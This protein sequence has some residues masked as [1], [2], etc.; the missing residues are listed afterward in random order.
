M[1]ALESLQRFINLSMLLLPQRA[2]RT[3]ILFLVLRRV[4]ELDTLRAETPLL[5]PPPIESSSYVDLLM[6]S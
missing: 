3:S 4:L 6:L 1:E 5:S 2:A